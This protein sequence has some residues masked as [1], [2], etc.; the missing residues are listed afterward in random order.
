MHLLPPF[1]LL[2]SIY[3]ISLVSTPC[4]F[5]LRHVSCFLRRYDIMNLQYTDADRYDYVH[6]GTWHEGVLNIDDYKIQMNKSGLV[7]SVCSE[8]CLKGQIKVS[9][10]QMRSQAVLARRPPAWT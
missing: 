3:R 10:P 1:S 8:P 7:R 9:R 4:L 5:S 6:V 2:L